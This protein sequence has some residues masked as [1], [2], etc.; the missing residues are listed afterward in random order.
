MGF[1]RAGDALKARSKTDEGYLIYN[2]KELRMFEGGMTDKC[3]FD[4]WCCY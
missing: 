2:E 1:T 3:P 4:C